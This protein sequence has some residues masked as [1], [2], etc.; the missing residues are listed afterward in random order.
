MLLE[1]FLVLF[2]TVRPGDIVKPY[3]QLS[4]LLANMMHYRAYIGISSYLVDLPAYKIMKKLLFATWLSVEQ[5]LF[6]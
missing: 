1:N 2:L 4:E 5:V 6:Y 3:L